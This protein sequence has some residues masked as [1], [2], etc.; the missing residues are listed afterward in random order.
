MAPENDTA[1]DNLYDGLYGDDFEQDFSLPQTDEPASGEAAS[2]NLSTHN[3]SE[4]V[5][6]SEPLPSKEQTA[7][8]HAEPNPLPPKPSSS[9]NSAASLSYS[10]QVAQQ[11]S[12]Y[13]QTP[14]QERQQ[15]F[16]NGRFVDLTPSG[17]PSGAPGA[18]GARPDRPIRPSEMKD[19]G[20]SASFHAYWLLTIVSY[21]HLPA[22]ITVDLKS[23]IPAVIF[24][25][26]LYEGLRNYFSE[27]GK[28]DACTIVRDPDGKSR[29]FAF[30]TFEDPSSV[31]AVMIR[32]HFLDGKAI[33]PKRAIPREEHLRNTRYFVGG[34]APHTTSESMRAF[35]STF[36]K[37]VDATVMVDR[38]TG[39]SKGFGFVT[40]EDNSNEAQL[41]GKIGLV[42]DDKQIE[43]KTAQP[44]NQR[45]QGRGTSN[46]DSYSERADMRV[47]PSAGNM[48][49]NIA[50]QQPQAD[51]QQMNMV[52]QRMMGQMANAPFNNMI[53]GGMPMMGG[54]NPMSM[55][56]GMNRF[57][58]GSMGG[59]GA[60]GNMGAAGMP[61]M[62]A[63]GG[64]SPMGGGMAGGMNNMGAGMAGVMG[65]MRLGM[66]PMGGAGGMN[67][68]G[69]GPVG[70]VG[71]M[72]AMNAGMGMGGGMR[73]G[74]GMMGA[75]RGRGGGAMN[76]GPGPARMMSR[77]Q[78]SFHPY[79]R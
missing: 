27:F 55:S 77:G 79:A 72:G 38:E 3:D 45:D 61:A 70:Q 21:P 44:R 67:P 6:P 15:R 33:D 66:G 75:A 42:L 49:Y 39:R 32:E 17:G 18:N 14:S 10:A 37:V 12:S 48:P 43:V 4:P 2:P 5:S 63:M 7:T 64:M 76:A 34:L 57:G 54:F 9:A 71:A 20:Q 22:T 73:P 50:P 53:G 47:A 41:V 28:V 8:K 31:N 52:Y 46:R 35:F 25:S 51:P 62:G 23:L 78:H 65:G 56:M 68:G 26:P 13:R 24:D 16:E 59:M 36:G 69:M 58:M 60:M 74:M 19:E 11:F 40:F 30:L 29:G 1:D